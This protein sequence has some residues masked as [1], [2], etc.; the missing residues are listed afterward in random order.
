MGHARSFPEDAPAE[1]LLEHGAPPAIVDDLAEC[2]T[3]ASLPADL[4]AF[5]YGPAF[6][7]VSLAEP[8]VLVRSVALSLAR[9]IS[10]THEAKKP[11]MRCA[12]PNMRKPAG[13]S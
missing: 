6:A 11:A 8:G 13:L 5:A 1:Y 7:A 2:M 10:L 4:N 3:I 12:D 9:D